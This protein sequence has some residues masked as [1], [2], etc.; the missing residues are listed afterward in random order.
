[1]IAVENNV[2]ER[3]DSY[4]VKCDLKFVSPNN[5]HR[6]T[7]F[8]RLLETPLYSVCKEEGHL[9]SLRLD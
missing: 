8:F 6:S 7:W 4:T 3:C 2:F 5:K 9:L 1:M